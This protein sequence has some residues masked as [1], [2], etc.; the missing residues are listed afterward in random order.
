MTIR[1]LPGLVRAFPL[2]VIRMRTVDV[3]RFFPII[4]DGRGTRHSGL[5]RR[6]LIDSRGR[7]DLGEVAGAMNFGVFLV[8]QNFTTYLPT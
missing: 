3:P 7:N 6:A 4:C 1:D 8:V 5:T 2:M